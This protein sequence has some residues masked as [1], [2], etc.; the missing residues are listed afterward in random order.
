MRGWSK[1]AWCASVIWCGE[2]VPQS[3][4]VD[5]SW[6]PDAAA[7]WADDGRFG[8]IRSDG[9]EQQDVGHSAAEASHP[10]ALLVVHQL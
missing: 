2:S 6:S 7:G 8:G 5:G 3:S 4:R 10:P 1:P 9:P